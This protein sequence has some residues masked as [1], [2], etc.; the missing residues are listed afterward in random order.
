M[1]F[2]QA[3]L[4][5]AID[6]LRDDFVDYATSGT[7]HNLAPIAE[8][9]LMS[10]SRIGESVKPDAMPARGSFQQQRFFTTKKLKTLLLM[11]RS[12]QGRFR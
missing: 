2:T 6:A 4:L 12:W 5:T 9:R 3:E 7:H 8:I 10:V 11:I 1:S